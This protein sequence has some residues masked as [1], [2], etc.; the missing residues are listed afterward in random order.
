VAYYSFEDEN[1][2]ACGSYE[3]FYLDRTAL[4]QVGILVDVQLNEGA[5]PL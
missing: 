4:E 5:A 2:E 3:L 1:G